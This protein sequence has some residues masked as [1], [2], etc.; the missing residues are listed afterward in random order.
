MTP[1]IQGVHCAPPTASSFFMSRRRGLC[2]AYP[3]T[4][5][6]LL[7]ASAAL[8]HARLALKTSLKHAD[9]EF[10]G[11]VDGRHDSTEIDC[12]TVPATFGNERRSRFR[13]VHCHQCDESARCNGSNQHNPPSAFS[14][15]DAA[16]HN[17][18]NVQRHLVSRSA[19]RNLR[20]EA[21][22][23]WQAALAAHDTDQFQLTM[24]MSFVTVT[25]PS[26]GAPLMLIP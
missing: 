7:I 10:P 14:A 12:R 16:V 11:L 15:S 4:P 2:R 21:I 24:R 18:F 9:V 17:N 5:C 1:T 25:K 6:W 23:Q 20:A 3:E 19:L 13:R 22:A 8:L 26:L